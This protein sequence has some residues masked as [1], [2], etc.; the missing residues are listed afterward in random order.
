MTAFWII[1]Y[2]LLA[3]LCALIADKRRGAGGKFFFK[4]IGG[5]A[6][7][8]FVAFWAL[9]GAADLAIGMLVIAYTCLGMGFLL[10]I[11]NPATKELAAKTGAHGEY[12]KCPFCAEAVRREAVKCKHCQSDLSETSPA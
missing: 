2:L 11:F 9:A 10:A 5:T 8:L 1:G 6:L 7:L 3:G 4:L 12:K